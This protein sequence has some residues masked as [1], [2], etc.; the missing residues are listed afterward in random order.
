[1]LGLAIAIIQMYGSQSLL[2]AA[3]LTC[4]L[5]TREDNLKKKSFLSVY[6]LLIYLSISYVS[7]DVTV[8][9]S[10]NLP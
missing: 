4:D 7:S 9:H 2:R 5:G 10:D 6:K 8:K 3:C 1:M